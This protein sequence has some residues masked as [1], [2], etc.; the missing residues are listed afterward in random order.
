[1]GEAKKKEQERRDRRSMASDTPL[2]RI[3]AMVDWYGAAQTTSPA[4]LLTDVRRKNDVRGEAAADAQR[5]VA[6]IIT[7]T[8]EAGTTVERAGNIDDHHDVED[9]A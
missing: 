2:S 8:P 9:S 6:A 5:D 3:I 4:V 7:A 1:M